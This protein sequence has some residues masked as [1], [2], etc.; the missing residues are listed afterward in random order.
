LR[1]HQQEKQ[2]EFLNIQLRKYE[3]NPAFIN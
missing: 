1:L 3:I 2:K